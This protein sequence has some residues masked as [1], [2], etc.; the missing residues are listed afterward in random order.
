MNMKM[1]INRVTN[2][3]VF[4]IQMDNI[5]ICLLVIII[6]V[7]MLLLNYN[8]F[9]NFENNDADTST[10]INAINNILAC[11]KNSS[12]CKRSEIVDF[13]SFKKK[14]GYRNFDM[15]LFLSLLEK[16]RKQ[17]LSLAEFKTFL[18]TKD[19]KV[20]E[21]S[22]TKIEHFDGQ[23]QNDPNE[24]IDAIKQFIASNDAK[25]AKYDA[26]YA[27]WKNTT[28][29]NWQRDKDNERNALYN[30][31]EQGL[32]PKSGEIVWE[33][34]FKVC[35]GGYG[36]C[37]NEAPEW[38]RKCECK[39][40]PS[41]C[42]HCF[43]TI[44]YFD[45]TENYC[46]TRGWSGG[47]PPQGNNRSLCIGPPPEKVDPKFNRLGPWEE[48]YASRMS[49]KFKIQPPEPPKPVFPTLQ[50]ICQDCR[51]YNLGNTVTD[52]KNVVFE[53]ANTCIAYIEKDAK[54]AAEKAAA[55][56]RAAEE[57]AAADKAAEEKA[58]ADKAAADQAASEKL[59]ADQAANKRKLYI[60]GGV[61]AGL[62]IC[63]C[64][65]VIIFFVMSKKSE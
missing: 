34:Q 36:G 39:G 64:I 14:L 57:K 42:G 15:D 54:A 17:P 55:D 40:F 65:V 21:K 23:P 11:D 19:Q 22:F 41:G 16:I 5:N 18:K 61:G 30:Q 25:S 45:S 58:A 20:V 10:V 51:Q 3:F 29:P 24:C 9:E 26:D 49:E 56:K 1:S 6:V 28:L 7:G 35:G 63:S 33:G 27:T 53:Q 59:A 46:K 38:Q 47:C 37:C 4:S 12:E 52:S 62:I 44:K 13:I 32:Y 50:S 48:F 60:G 31:W 8:N 2:N 43:G